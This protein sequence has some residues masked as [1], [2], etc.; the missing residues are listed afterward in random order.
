MLALSS[1]TAFAATPHLTDIQPQ[2]VQPGHPIKLIG[3]GFGTSGRVF[4]NDRYLPESL[5]GDSQIILLAPAFAGSFPVKVCVGGVADDC[6]NE[7]LVRIVVA[8][9]PD[10]T[11]ADV[12][13]GIVLTGV[14][15]YSD[16]V[17]QAM[18][19]ASR[20]KLM[21]LQMIDQAGIASRVRLERQ[22][23]LAPG[24]NDYCEYRQHPDDNRERNFV[25]GD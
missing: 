11:V 14:K 13:N 7:I 3:T 1:A 10:P 20:Q 2:E 17:L 22:R 12:D 5:W 6:S 16:A 24:G 21:T 9:S 15:Q 19:D 18:L 23:P 25:A 4:L 8:A